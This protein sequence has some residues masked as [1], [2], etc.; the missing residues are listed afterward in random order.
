VKKILRGL[1]PFRSHYCCT[2]KPQQTVSCGI[3][4]T[5]G[6]KA[7]PIPEEEDKSTQLFNEIKLKTEPAAPACTTIKYSALRSCKKVVPKTTS[8][9]YFTGALAS[10]IW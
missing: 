5:Q 3:D 10:R 9:P 8:V 1:R 2:N 7:S 6:L 4:G